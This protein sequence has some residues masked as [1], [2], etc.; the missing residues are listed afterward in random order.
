MMARIKLVKEDGYEID[1]YR[2]VMPFR[3]VDECPCC[4][5]TCEYGDDYWPYPT[6]GKPS[7]VTMKCSN[8]DNEWAVRIQIDFTAR[9]LE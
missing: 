5:E 3:V 4:G 1:I 8:C 2:M 9:I 6:I 7:K